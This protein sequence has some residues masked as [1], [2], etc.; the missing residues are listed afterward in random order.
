VRVLAVA[1][2]KPKKWFACSQ[3]L[4]LSN[5]NVVWQAPKH[6]DVLVLAD[7]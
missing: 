4:K 3:L 5:A 6:G 2:K 7:G 1:R